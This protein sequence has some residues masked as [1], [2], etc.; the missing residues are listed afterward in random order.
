MCHLRLTILFILYVHACYKISSD[1]VTVFCF[2][3]VLYIIFNVNFHLSGA[4]E[5]GVTEQ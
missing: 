5:R 4:L 1:I 2:K 3:K